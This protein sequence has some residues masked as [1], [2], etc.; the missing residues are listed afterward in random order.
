MLCIASP[1]S[2]YYCT[3]IEA[4]S[5]DTKAMFR[6]MNSL[7]GCTHKSVLPECDDDPDALTERLVAYF[8]H[9]IADIGIQ[10]IIARMQCQLPLFIHDI[11]CRI[12]N[13]L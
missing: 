13:P 4:S 5:H 8:T 3:E 10:L 11:E 9:K 1:K 2:A 6:I 12:V 7:M